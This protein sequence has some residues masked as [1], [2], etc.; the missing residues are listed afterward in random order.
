MASADELIGLGLR[1]GDR[2]RFRRGT[3]GRWHEG[4][5]VGVE[6]D[7]SVA[8]VDRKG[9]ARSIALT[10]V[11]VRTT[12]PRGAALWEPLPERVARAEQL[13]LW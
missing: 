11:E 1:H 3:G 8:I 7:G 6:R 9:A 2:V 13:G 12:G 10:S 4:K 5:A